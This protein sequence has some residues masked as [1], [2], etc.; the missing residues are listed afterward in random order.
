[1][2]ADDVSRALETWRAAIREADAPTPGTDRR[3]VLEAKA[4]RARVAYQHTI[5]ANAEP[6]GGYGIRS[7]RARDARTR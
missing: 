1:M 4:E 3:A 5:N 7:R 2:A 6:G